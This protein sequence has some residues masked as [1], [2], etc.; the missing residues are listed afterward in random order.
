M[1][2]RRMHGATVWI[3][4]LILLVIA[5]GV[6]GYWWLESSRQ[7]PPQTDETP[8]PPVV[9]ERPA[10]AAPRYPV[11]HIV[12]EPAEPAGVTPPPT[13]GDD[14]SAAGILEQFV[15]ADTYA[16]L[17]RPEQL[18]ERFV[19]TIDNLPRRQLPER[20]RPWRR[21]DGAFV[22]VGDGADA[23][24]GTAN[25]A[26]YA[27]LIRA[28]LSLDSDLVLR[29]YRHNYPRL[30]AAYRQLGYPDG[31]FND[32]LVEVLTHLGDTP[33]LTSRPRLAR[34]NVLYEYADPALEQR[35]IG[36]RLL[37]RLDPDS[38]GRLL[39]QLGVYREALAGDAPPAAD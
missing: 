12:A 27:A 13:I 38:R 25:D 3:V 2:R 22:A 17:F 4:L 23:T 36:Q 6:A 32:R 24:I 16:A 19:A 15:G 8:A 7:P 26:R 21:P 18:V 34:P 31:H 10:P 33:A 14:T 11:E 30:Q 39:E 5:A 20:L 35:S 1:H 28:F 9:D 29:T 37:L